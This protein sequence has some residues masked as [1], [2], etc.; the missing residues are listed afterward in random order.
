MTQQNASKDRQTHSNSL[1]DVLI[2]SGSAHPGLAR[3]I[4][5]YLGLDLSPTTIRK[6]S[7]DNYYIQLGTSV[8][9]KQVFIVQPLS[10]PC[11][12]NLMELLLMLDIARSGAAKDVC[13]V[14]PYY[15]YARSDK[16]DAPRIS[17]AARL[18]ADLLMASG[19]TQVITMTLH[20]P[21]AHGFFSVPTDHLTA[22]SVFVEHL[23]NKDLSNTVVVAPDIGHAKRTGKLARALELPMAAGEKMRLSD[24]TVSI[25]GLMGS[26]DRKDV[27]IVDDEI[28]TAGT[29]TELVRYL[30]TNTQVRRVTVVGTHGLFTGPAVRRLNAIDEIDEIVVTNTVPLPDDRR[31]ERLVIL[32][33]A[34][35]FGEVIRRNVQGESVGSLF[36]FWPMPQ[37]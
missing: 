32:S 11:S 4:A 24:N 37:H 3:A 27:L 34:R 7:N 15:S 23:S 6:F 9:G 35:I 8:R 29:I 26:V 10:P 16:K 33:V 19:A 28:A 36:E 13:A 1:D 14:I 12:D 21:Q 31:P 22:H 17:I 20:S 30:K 5:G 2:F 25:T 18:V